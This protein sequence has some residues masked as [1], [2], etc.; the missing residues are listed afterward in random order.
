[1]LD[2]ADESAI[3][4]V[5]DGWFRCF[6]ADRQPDEPFGNFTVRVQLVAEVKHGSAVNVA[7]VDM[8]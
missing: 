3:V 1:M 4:R 7:E 5:I 6:A 2:N 8:A